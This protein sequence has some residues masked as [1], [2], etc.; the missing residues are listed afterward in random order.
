MPCSVVQS[1]PRASTRCAVFRPPV[2]RRLADRILRL[3]TTSPAQAADYIHSDVSSI[4]KRQANKQGPS[5]S[6]SGETHH[7]CFL[8]WRKQSVCAALDFDPSWTA[9]KRNTPLEGFEAHFLW[10]NHE[11]HEIR[12]CARYTAR[13][14]TIV[15]K[16][17]HSL[18]C[19]S[20][21]RVVRASST[22]GATSRSC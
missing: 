19:T 10:T 11:M 5:Q 21:V 3:L 8:C 13:I 20:N 4:V 1:T 12:P 6:G 22:D 17:I 16:A 15:T 2:Y 14:L 9:S 7:R 18:F